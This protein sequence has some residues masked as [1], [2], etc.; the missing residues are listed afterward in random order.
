M[1]RR[2]IAQPVTIAGTGLFTDKPAIATIEPAAPGLGVGFVHNSTPIHADIELLAHSPIKLFA[3]LPA[4]HTCLAL[5]NAHAIT[6]EHILA[7]L[8]GLGITDATIT[9]GDTGE[10]PIGDGSAQLFTNA[11]T[12]AGTTQLAGNLA[13]ITLTKPITVT[14]GNAS[15]TAQPATKTSYTYIFKPTESSPIKPQTATWNTSKETFIT[16]IAPARTFSLQADAEHMQSL[17]L[18]ASFTTTDLLVLDNAGEPINN[19]FRFVN[20]PARHKLLDLVGDLA[21]AG[22]PILANITA[23]GSGHALNHQ[24]AKKLYDLYQK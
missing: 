17:G 3:N 9:L 14:N 20:E 22:A 5:G 21:L 10:L 23:T 18:F 1:T 4:R 2:T 19:N 7:A 24:L 16:D 13:P 11:I 15:I 6:T 12:T 8:A